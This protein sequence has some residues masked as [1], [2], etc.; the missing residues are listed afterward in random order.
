MSRGEGNFLR[1]NGVAAVRI[2]VCLGGGEH[3][4]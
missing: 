2:Y 4:G 3:K 1:G